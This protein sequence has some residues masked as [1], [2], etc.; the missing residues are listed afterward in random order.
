MTV[1]IIIRHFKKEK[2][3][4]MKIL[5]INKYFYIKGG[6][7]AYYFN[8][9]QLLE[10]NGHEVIHFSMK[11]PKNRPS[12]YEDYFVDEIDYNNQSTTD[13]IRQAAKIIYSLEAR[14]KLRAL[15]EA[16]RP[17]VAHLHNI[18]H[19][20]SPSII[21][22]LKRANIPIVLTA[23]D[24]KL[25]CPN[26]KLY[27]HNKV[28]EQCK[29]HHYYHCLT[30]KCSK[31]STMASA[32]NTVEMYLHHFMKSYEQIDCIL[33]PS[34]FLK[35]KFIEFGYSKDRI[36][37]IYNFVDLSAYEPTF[38]YEPYFVCFGRVSEEKGIFTL[39]KAMREVKKGKL[40]IIGDGPKLEEAKQYAAIAEL[41]HVEFLGYQ[42]GETLKSLIANSQFVTINSEWY[43]NNPMSVIESMALGKAIVGSA[44]GGIPELIDDG[45]N[46]YLYEAGNEKVLAAQLNRMLDHPEQAEVFGKVSYEKAQQLFSEKEHYRHFMDIIDTVMKKYRKEG[47]V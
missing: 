2:G 26:Y 21:H 27:Q 5:E 9:I 10:A 41:D 7:E 34:Q 33:T 17:D 36:E 43:E 30:N 19:Q 38:N 24:Y 35:N 42:T 1:I 3:I 22:E 23:H 45:K 18:Y 28:C 8:L 39:L 4:N 29:G 40:L 31:D 6:C 32:V 13:K 47:I 46:G 25:V 16:H 12:P 11:S 20:L 14:K 44:I 37:H 15:I